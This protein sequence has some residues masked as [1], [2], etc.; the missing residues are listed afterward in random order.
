MPRPTTKQ[1]LLEKAQTTFQKLIEA[2]EN[3]TDCQLKSPFDFSDNP[4]LKEA[5]WSRD[6]NV[7][8][9]MIHLYEWHQLML[10]FVKNNNCGTGISS[11]KNSPFLPQG[12]TWKTYGQ[13]NVMFWNKHQTTSL[14]DAKKM[15]QQSHSEVLEKIKDFSDEQLFTKKFYSWTGTTNLGS[16]FISSTASHYEWAIKKLKLH[17][18]KVK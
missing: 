5:H 8:D 10:K 14:D 3:M 18:K 9:I 4:S 12:Y 11:E 17:C 7:R 15:L 2:V 6:K 13:M 1:T 16:Y